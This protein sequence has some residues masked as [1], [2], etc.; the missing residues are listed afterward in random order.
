M[1]YDALMPFARRFQRRRRME[2]EAA[3][4]HGL[5][6]NLERAYPA[7]FE[8]L[9][10]REIEEAQRCEVCRS[11]PG[12]GSTPGWAAADPPQGHHPRP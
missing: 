11:E 2:A 10:A 7:E 8:A 4:M 1:S 9:R 5:I 6:E 3:I 12:D